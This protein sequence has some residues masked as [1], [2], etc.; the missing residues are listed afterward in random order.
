MGVA[1]H[2]RRVVA[3]FLGDKAQP[4]VL[5][6]LAE[7]WVATLVRRARSIRVVQCLQWLSACPVQGTRVT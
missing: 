1:S 3:D 6:R 2:D 4:N 7:Q 5:K